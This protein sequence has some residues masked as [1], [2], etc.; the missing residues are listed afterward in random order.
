MGLPLC[1][2]L[3]VDL[4]SVRR[5]GQRRGTDATGEQKGVDKQEGGEWGTCH[6]VSVN[7]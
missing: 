1:R 4:V 7:K 2:A 5:T 6:V 3:S